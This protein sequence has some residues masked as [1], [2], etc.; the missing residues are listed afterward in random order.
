MRRIS[1]RIRLRWCSSET[2]QT[3]ETSIQTVQS[4]SGSITSSNYRKKYILRSPEEQIQT[5]HN[6]C[7]VINEFARNLDHKP[8]KVSKR[9]AMHSEKYME[10]LKKRYENIFQPFKQ[11]Y[12]RERTC[13]YAVEEAFPA[14]QV[15]RKLFT[16]LKLLLP[17]FRPQSVLDFGAGVGSGAWASKEMFPD[18]KVLA[19]E[20]SPT[21]TTLGSAFTSTF[22]EDVK[23]TTFL[24]FD[25]AGSFD[26]VVCSFVLG[27][28]A[29]QKRNEVV[30]KLWQC[31]KPGG[32][33]VFID[34][35]DKNGFKRIGNARATVLE[36][37]NAVTV[38]PCPHDKPCPL[39]AS[40]GLRTF[41]D[42]IC[43]APHRIVFSEL[44]YR[45][46]IREKLIPENSR[47]QNQHL[48]K[49][50]Y[51]MLTKFQPSQ[52]KQLTWRGGWSR[53]IRP[54]IKKGGHTYLDLCSGTTGKLR[55]DVASR[56]LNK[57]QF[58][59]TR[60]AKWGDLVRD[61]YRQDELFNKD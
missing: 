28:T 60:H 49:Y 17:E 38:A 42:E 27:E 25:S 40:R 59:T 58:K 5:N 30:K 51:V 11:F 24:P 47:F 12:D 39:L 6:F 13:Q 48:L 45:S 14:F 34:A 26:L 36:M 54:P 23:W 53:V 32:S 61:D 4:D 55:R 41:K 57:E 8:E 31:V 33:I 37:E 46:N 9:R 1:S 44:P 3:V 19:L 7:E 15:T 29:P 35:G 50:S 52:V 18:S 2:K 22:Q 43:V 21:M 16:E 20:P 10:K 56:G